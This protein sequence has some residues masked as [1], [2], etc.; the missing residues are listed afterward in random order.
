MET[1]ISP[2]GCVSG[3][4]ERL[5][6]GPFNMQHT[7]TYCTLSFT[8]TQLLFSVRLKSGTGQRCQHGHVRRQHLCTPGTV[9]DLLMGKPAINHHDW[10]MVESSHKHLVMTWGWFM[11]LALPHDW[12][13]SDFKRRQC[14]VVYWY[15]LSEPWEM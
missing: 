5:S 11:T 6:V 12:I 13:T 4:V 1:V 2:F 7:D 3:C 14:L 15:P 10:G 9:F 8:S